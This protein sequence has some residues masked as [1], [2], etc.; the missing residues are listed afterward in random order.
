MLTTRRT[1]SPLMHELDQHVALSAAVGTL[2]SEYST[3]AMG[4]EVCRV[5]PGERSPGVADERMPSPA[6]P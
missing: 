3:M 2:K 5:L 4:A 1:L 6:V